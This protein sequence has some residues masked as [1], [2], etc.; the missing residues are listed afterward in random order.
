MTVEAINQTNYRVATANIGLKNVLLDDYTWSKEYSPETDTVDIRSKVALDA[1][2]YTIKNDGTVISGINLGQPQPIVIL[3][4]NENLAAYVK[5]MKE[6]NGIL[7]KIIADV[8]FTGNE[9]KAEEVS[10]VENAI[11]TKK[12]K[13]ARNS[14]ASLWKFMTTANQMANSALKG[15][16]YGALTG[17]ALLGGSWVFKALPKAFTKEG[18]TL[19]NTI[20]HPLKNIGKSG[21]VIAGIGSAAVL[22]YQ[23][24]AGKLAANQKTA[25]I[26]HKLKT[27]H[28]DK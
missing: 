6:Q 1:G 4:K 14:V 8:S 12:P 13:S 20:R 3:N 11:E 22:G 15:L 7:N 18:P 10:E 17:V 9:T 19:W 2:N 21:K 28:R 24:V 27:G 25:V 23:L 5:N 26:D 16:F